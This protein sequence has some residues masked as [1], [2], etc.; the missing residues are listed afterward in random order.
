MGRGRKPQVSALLVGSERLLGHVPGH[1]LPP[2]APASSACCALGRPAAADTLGD[3]TAEVAPR[4]GQFALPKISAATCDA[5]SV[6]IEGITWL[7]V[8]RVMLM[9]E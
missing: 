3:P 5:A 4:L 9:L 1:K 8:S 2:R 7:Y 6:C